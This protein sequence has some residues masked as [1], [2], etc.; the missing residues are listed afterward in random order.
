MN[1]LWSAASSAIKVRFTRSP[2]WTVTFGPGVVIVALVNPQPR[3]ASPWSVRFTDGKAVPRTVAGVKALAATDSDA[4]ENSGAAAIAARRKIATE[5][6]A[7]PRTSPPVIP[8]PVSLPSAHDLQGRGHR[9]VVEPAELRTSDHEVTR[10]Q[11]L[12]PVEIRVA[13]DHVDLQVEVDQVERV[14]DV[15][16]TKDD[17]HDEFRLDGESP[18]GVERREVA[19]RVQPLALSDVGDVEIPIPLVRIDLHDDVGILRQRVRRDEGLERGE[20]DD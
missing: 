10:P 11:R 15:E 18:G 2:R 12:E 8:P 3:P 13:R 7:G 16:G 6:S 4:G 14:G 20:A 17:L 9:V 1:Q 19:R 5:M